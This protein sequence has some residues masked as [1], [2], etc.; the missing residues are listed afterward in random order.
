M[1]KILLVET[2]RKEPTS[3]FETNIIFER[4]QTVNHLI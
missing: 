3:K 1:I 4:T 2:K